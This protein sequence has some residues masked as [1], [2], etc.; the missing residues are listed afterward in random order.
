MTGG[1]FKMTG[2]LQNVKLPSY[3][4][5]LSGFNP[6]INAGIYSAKNSTDKALISQ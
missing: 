4:Q 5:E 2:G 1:D 6:M 3:K